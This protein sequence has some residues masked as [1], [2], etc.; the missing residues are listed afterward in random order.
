MTDIGFFILDLINKEGIAID[1][2]IEQKWVENGAKSAL[3]EWMGF[4]SLALGFVTRGR[5]LRHWPSH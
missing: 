1:I 5:L 2:G 3:S 4:H